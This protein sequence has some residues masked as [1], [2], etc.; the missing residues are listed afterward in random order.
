M[1]MDEI[2][3]GAVP[4]FLL[5]RP[6]FRG[7]IVP[8]TVAQFGKVYDFKIT[9]TD[10]VAWCLKHR[11]CGLCG[12]RMSQ[13]VAFVGGEVS[14]ESRNFTDPPMHRDC[15][16]YAVAHCPYLGGKIGY[17][18]HYRPEGQK[19]EGAEMQDTSQIGIGLAKDYR[20][21]RNIIV[22]TEWIAP[23]EWYVRSGAGASR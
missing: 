6:K 13:A 21:N 4:R 15:A 18:N 20:S 14:M 8:F 10:K 19:I 5:G 3:A 9:D 22:A 2:R 7:L 11:N 16:R 12:Y 23:V 17:A 1:E